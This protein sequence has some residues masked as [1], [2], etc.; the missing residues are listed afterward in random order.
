MAGQRAV[1]KENTPT[2]VFLPA[3]PEAP[4]SSLPGK[5]APHHSSGLFSCYS[6]SAA[7]EE[8]ERANQPLAPRLQNGHPALLHPRSAPLAPLE[9]GSGMLAP[10]TAPR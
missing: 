2:A 5:T 9:P 4:S 1:V 8:P 10:M 6:Y 7:P 3:G